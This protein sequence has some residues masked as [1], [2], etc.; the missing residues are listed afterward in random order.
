MSRLKME[1]FQEV[2]QVRQ[3]IMFNNNEAQTVR[4]EFTIFFAK[5]TDMIR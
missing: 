5:E 3:P 4:L 1:S 2:D